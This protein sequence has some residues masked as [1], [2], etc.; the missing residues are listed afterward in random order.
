MPLAH[1]GSVTL[2]AL[3]ATIAL[4]SHIRRI[5][6]R[7]ARQKRHHRPNIAAIWAI[8][9]SVINRCMKASNV[10]CV[11]AYREKEISLGYLGQ[12]YRTTRF[13]HLHLH[14]LLLSPTDE[15][16]KCRSSALSSRS[17]EPRGASTSREVL[18]VLRTLGRRRTWCVCHAS[19][20]GEGYGT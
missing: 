7:F 3:P 10:E 17:L 13:I 11:I 1:D 18:R 14:H 9:C 20:R 5:D 16:P 2:A 8:M 19:A 12:T 4:P 15:S 6:I